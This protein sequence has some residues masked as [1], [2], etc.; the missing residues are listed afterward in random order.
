MQVSTILSIL[1]ELIFSHTSSGGLHQQ[2]IGGIHIYLRGVRLIFQRHFLSVPFRIDRLSVRAG[3]LARK[4]SKLTTRILIRRTELKHV[5]RLHRSARAIPS[6]LAVSRSMIIMAGTYQIVVLS[7]RISDR[8]HRNR[9]NILNRGLVRYGEILRE[10][11]LQLIAQSLQLIH[12]GDRS[13]PSVH[14]F[15]VNGKLDVLSSR[16]IAVRPIVVRINLRI[17]RQLSQDHISHRLGNTP[18][19]LA[20]LVAAVI[21]KIRQRL[22]QLRTDKVKYNATLRLLYLR[23]R[24]RRGSYQRNTS[25]QIQQL[26]I[27]KRTDRTD[28]FQINLEIFH[29]RLFLGKGL[30][31]INTLVAFSDL[32]IQEIPRVLGQIIHRAPTV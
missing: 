16:T 2:T 12:I 20:L 7:V 18:V 4:I 30:Q 8:V 21:R 28:L 31:L 14:L 22:L 25:E 24:C 13:F 11:S 26:I 5:H 32:L 3:H 23:H 10:V 19:I 29:V 17:Q 1:V 15:T 9:E 6:G 27:E